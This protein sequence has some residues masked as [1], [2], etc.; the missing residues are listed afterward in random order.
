MVES[1]EFRLAWWPISTEDMRISDADR[2][3]LVAITVNSTTQSERRALRKWCNENG[4]VKM[5]RTDAWDDSYYSVD[6]NAHIIN[7]TNHE[8]AVL[9]DPVV[10]RRLVAWLES[11]P[12]RNHAVMVK[13]DLPALRKAVRGE[14]ARIITDLDDDTLHVVSLANGMLATELALRSD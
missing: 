12:Q 8:N 13:M 11:L 7:F 10:M 3:N 4:V 9:A 5:F 2:Q 6:D 14:V 1:S